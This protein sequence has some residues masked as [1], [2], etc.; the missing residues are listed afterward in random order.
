[1]T[2]EGLPAVRIKPTQVYISGVALPGVIDMDGITIAPGGRG[3]VNVMTVRFLVG[4]VAVDAPD[5]WPDE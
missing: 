5:V 3:G 1:M 2:D 4:E